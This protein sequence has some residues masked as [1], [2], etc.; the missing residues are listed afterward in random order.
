MRF[1]KQ[2]IGTAPSRLAASTGTPLCVGLDPSDLVVD[3][4]LLVLA[5]HVAVKHLGQLEL[6]SPGAI[7]MQHDLARPH[8]FWLLAPNLAF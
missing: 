5:N 6:I 3:L 2:K 7:R 1:F 8:P 4:D